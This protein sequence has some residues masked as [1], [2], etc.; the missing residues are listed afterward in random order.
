[1]IG[2]LTWSLKLLIEM[3]KIN[4][5][6]ENDPVIGVDSRTLEVLKGERNFVTFSLGSIHI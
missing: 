6:A 3:A 4:Q 2:I 1:M 5:I